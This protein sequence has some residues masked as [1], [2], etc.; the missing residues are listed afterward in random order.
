[1]R[2]LYFIGCIGGAAAA[3]YYGQ[4]FVADNADAN[5]IIITVLTVF[6]GFL[7][8]IITIVADPALLTPGSWRKG[9]L[10]RDSIEARLIRH[11]YL[12]FLYLVGIALIFVASLVHKV[13]NISADIKMWIDRLYLFFAVAA[14]LI[15]FAL[16]F[17]L[18]RL[19]MKRMDAEIERRRDE[20]KIEPNPAPD[21]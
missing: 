7:V 5:V 10:Q 4:P 8:A 21:I 20:A 17:S 2:T 3:A 18:L 15:T 9:E 6:A 12:F 14:F 13:P 19:Q 16:P 1:M 11:T